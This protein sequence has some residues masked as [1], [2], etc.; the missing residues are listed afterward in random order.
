[1]L[2]RLTVFSAVYDLMGLEDNMSVNRIDILSP[3]QLAARSAGGKAKRKAGGRK[4]SDRRERPTKFGPTSRGERRGGGPAQGASERRKSQ[5]EQKAT[6]KA[7]R[8]AAAK[9]GRG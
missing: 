9:K 2:W 6:A 1:M 8:S 4:G 7:T 5:T 3:A